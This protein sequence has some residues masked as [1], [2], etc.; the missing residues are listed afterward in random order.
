MTV[1]PEDFVRTWQTGETLEV[2]AKVLGTTTLRATSRASRYRKQGIN[3]KRFS[4]S[5]D[6][7]DI[8]EIQ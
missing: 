7:I 4:R 2:V 8:E 1:S 5:I 6:S 3:L